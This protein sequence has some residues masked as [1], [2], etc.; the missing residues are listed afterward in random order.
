MRRDE[1]DNVYYNTTTG[2]GGD[3]HEVWYRFAGKELGY[4]GNNATSQLT[5]SAAIADRQTWQ[6]TGAFRNGAKYANSFTNFA[7]STGAPINSYSQGA[8]SGSYVV[9]RSGETLRSLA[10]QLYGDASLWYK[11]ADANGMAGDVSLSEGQRLS[12][13]AG[14]ARTHI[15]DCART[16]F[17][18]ELPGW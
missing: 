14:V 5:E 12:L 11:I 18:A 7:Q 17:E 6:D 8:A 2:L 16:T 3:P 13:P 10:Q 1:A 4:V 15:E 9:Q